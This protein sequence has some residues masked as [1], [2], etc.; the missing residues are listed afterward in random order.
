MIK[1]KL[2]NCRYVNIS[3]FKDI[4]GT[5]SYI[6]FDNKSF[7]FVPRRIFYITD[8]PKN[9]VRGDHAHNF[10]EQVLIVIS[11]RVEIKL[12]DGKISS[13]LTL[14]NDQFGLYIP[15][16]IWSNQ[17]FILKN[18]SMVVLASH[19]YDAE[20]YTRNFDQFIKLKNV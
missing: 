4:R 18:S 17:R 15:A 16:G 10:C 9:V 8:A 19:N 6:D 1:S 20:D 12:F 7:P 13:T 14:Q 3:N 5:L 11:G 2:E